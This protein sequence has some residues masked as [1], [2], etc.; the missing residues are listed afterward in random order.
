[1]TA[2]EIEMGYLLGVR[3]TQR[4]A[5]PRPTVIF[6]IIFFIFDRSPELQ[7]FSCSLLVILRRRR[8]DVYYFPAAGRIIY[9]GKPA[10]FKQEAGRV[11]IKVIKTKSSKAAE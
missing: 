10:G 2:S 8:S 3:N 4:A 7:I 9:E 5:F 6:I 1:M 11:D